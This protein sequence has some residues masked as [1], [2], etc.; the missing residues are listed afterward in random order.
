MCRADALGDM[1]GYA[2]NTKDT[3]AKAASGES[4]GVSHCESADIMH[5]HQ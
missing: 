5:K 3:M 2:P 1:L 4:G